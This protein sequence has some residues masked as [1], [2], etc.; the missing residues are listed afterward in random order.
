MEGH[1]RQ[2]RHPRHGT[3]HIGGRAATAHD[4]Q[5]ERVTHSTTPRYPVTVRSRLV[6]SLLVRHPCPAAESLHVGDL[7]LFPDEED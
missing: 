4:A 7:P 3:T 6:N 5:P 1:D 2:L